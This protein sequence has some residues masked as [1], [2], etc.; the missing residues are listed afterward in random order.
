MSVQD[1]LRDC[2]QPCALTNDL[3]AP[4]HRLLIQPLPADEGEAIHALVSS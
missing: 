3:I 4:G 2:L 1:R